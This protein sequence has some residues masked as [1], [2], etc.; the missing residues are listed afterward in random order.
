MR[1]ISNKQNSVQ[2]LLDYILGSE[3]QLRLL[4]VILNEVEAPLGVSQLAVMAGLSPQWA[5]RALNRLVECGIVLRIGGGRALKFGLRDKH[6][7]VG[8]LRELFRAEQQ[9]FDALVSSLRTMLLGLREIRRAWIEKLPMSVRH[10]V[11]I[12]VVAKARAIGWLGEEV[13]S[14]LIASEKQ[15]D[16]IIEVELFTQA[17][18]PN[19]G[20]DAVFL[21]ALE[22]TTPTGTGRALQTHQQAE[23]RSLLLAKGIAKLIRTKPS[24]IKRAKNH[25]N[26]LMHEDQGLASGDISEWR[27]LL[28]TYSPER[29][30]QLLVS[31]NS[32]ADRLRQS[33]PFFAVL[34]A[35]EREE[36]IASMEDLG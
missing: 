13:R 2:Y 30:S 1:P 5:R 17:D 29:V 11:E 10:P 14:R 32:R 9:Y 34:T 27:R 24:L 31:R 15:F 23:E 26:R 33:L 36:L 7:L 16:I 4:R 12:V 6:P 19:P 28:E 18:A 20:R 25:L 35:E 21:V 8:A 3:A 22:K